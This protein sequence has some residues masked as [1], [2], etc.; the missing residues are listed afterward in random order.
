MDGCM[1]QNTMDAFSEAGYFINVNI[2]VFFD[3]SINIIAAALGLETLLPS[4]N[5]G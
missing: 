4:K 2:M 5:S 1:V 3:H